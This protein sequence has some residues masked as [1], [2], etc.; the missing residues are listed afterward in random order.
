MER[1]WSWS[2]V[3]DREELVGRMSAVSRLPQYLS[4][5]QRCARLRNGEG[6]LDTRLMQAMLTGAVT[7]AS[8][9]MPA[10]RMERL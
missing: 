9:T 5:G 2:R 4:L 8:Y 1:R 3:T 6:A 10:R 7:V